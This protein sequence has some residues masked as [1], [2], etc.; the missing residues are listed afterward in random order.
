M[1]HVLSTRVDVDINV[2]GLA[3]REFVLTGVTNT[4]RKRTDDTESVADIEIVCLRRSWKS[5][6]RS[7]RQTRE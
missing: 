1:N 2:L 4:M 6:G 7:L 5:S 3:K